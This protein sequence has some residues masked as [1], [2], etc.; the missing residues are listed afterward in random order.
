[1]GAKTASHVEEL[2]RQHSGRVY[3]Y[4][5]RR[6]RDVPLAQSIT[7]DVFRIAW[8]QQKEPGDDALAWLLVTAR[9]LVANELRAQQR[10]RSLVEKLGSA[11]LSRRPAEPDGTS[12]EVRE[13]LAT[14]REAEREILMLAYWDSLSL[15]EIAAILGCSADSAKSRLFRA[16]KA[17]SRKTPNQMLKGGTD[18]GQH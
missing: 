7:N 8:Q 10:R 11:E 13:V 9:N 4:V 15:A 6:L 1:M 18:H 2:H 14:L 5:F 17:F 12:H 16:R 3:G